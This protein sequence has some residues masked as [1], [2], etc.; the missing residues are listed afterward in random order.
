[1]ES[2]LDLYHTDVD[3]S[4]AL[5]DDAI[6]D[7][8]EMKKKFKDMGEVVVAIREMQAKV[9]KDMVAVYYPANAAAAQESRVEVDLLSIYVGN[10][11]H[12]HLKKFNSINNHGDYFDI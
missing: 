7:W 6:D 2:E 11:D 8:N 9:E 10:V 1:M 5:D 12:A 4:I 3:M